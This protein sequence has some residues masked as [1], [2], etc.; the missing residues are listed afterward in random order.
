MI[1]P[2]ASARLGRLVTRAFVVRALA[3]VAIGL[4]LRMIVG[5]TPVWWLAWTAPAALLVLAFKSDGA[6]ARWWVTLAALIGTSANFQYFCLVVPAYIAVLFTVGQAL[7]WGRV[8]RTTRALVLRFPRWWVA[9][10][11]PALWVSV[12]TLLA[13]LLPDGDW[14][15]LAYSQADVLPVLQI[16]SVLGVS[17]LLFVLALVPSTLALGITYGRTLQNGW[18]AY[19]GTALL[20]AATVSFGELRLRE[21]VRGESVTVGLAAID[22]AIGPDSSQK[23]ADT[24]LDQYDR[25]VVSLAA[26]GAKLVVLP[27]KVAVL[28]AGPLGVW[29]E[30][31]AGLAARNH[32]WLEVGMGIAGAHPTNWAWLYTPEGVL[33]ATYEKHKLAPPERAEDYLAGSDFSVREIHGRSLGLAIC[34]DMHFASLGRDYGQRHVDAMLVP[35]WDFNYLDKWLESRTTVTRGVENGYAIVRSSKE[36][37]LTVSDA[38]GRILAE[39]DSSRMPGSTLLATVLIPKQ[40]A[41]LYTR[42]GNAFGWLCVLISAA[43]L[44]VKSR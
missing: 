40:I 1:V 9:L 23:Y 35:A 42:I 4:L 33:S 16:T 26:G 31:F 41:T 32:V 10:V 8:V 38:Y 43:L 12:D 18:I 30:H 14:A 3:A 28:K 20:V 13:A 7:L 24:I 44:F 34:K 39:R 25:L 2:G 17:G 29:R 36:G 21:P 19:A 11:F 37:S 15:S 22:D 6:Q 5:L 27:E